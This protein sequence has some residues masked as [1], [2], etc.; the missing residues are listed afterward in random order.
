MSVQS[1]LK[2][3]ESIQKI[4]SFWRGGS[5]LILSIQTRSQPL[6]NW[7]LFLV[8]SVFLISCGQSSKQEKVEKDYSLVKDTLSVEIEQLNEAGKIVGFSVAMVDTTGLLFNKGFGLADRATGKAYTTETTQYVA[9]ISKTLIGISLFKAQELGKLNLDEPI[10]NYLPFDVTNPN[11]PEIPITIRQLAIHTSSIADSDI[12]WENDYLLLQKNHPDGTGILRYFNEPKSKRPVS[13][14]LRDLLAESGDLNKGENFTDHR[15]NQKFV[16]SNVGSTLCAWVIEIATGIPYQTFTEKYILDPLQMDASG[17]S[18]VDSNHH[19]TL[20]VTHEQVMAD[21]TTVSFPSGGL[22]TSS[23]DLGKYLSELIRGYSGK[24][25]ILTA[26]SY[27]ELFRK[28][29]IKSQ[30]PEGVEAN[31]GIFMD[32]SKRGLGYSGYDPGLMAYMYFNPENLIGKVITINTDTDFDEE[33]RPTLNRVWELLGS[34]ET[35]LN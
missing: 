22:I 4:Q 10:N 8:L 30:L 6:W 14:F 24:G 26:K 16:Y 20:Y 13:D 18:I 15:P 29:L 17:W 33:V 9:S 27:G 21:Y 7:V 35:K 34:Y 1:A 19:S 23:A 31:V 32:Y 5:M 2:E 25:R 3:N 12:F 11:F 28:Q